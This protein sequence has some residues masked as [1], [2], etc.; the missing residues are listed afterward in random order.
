MT[1]DD[2]IA[3]PI[4]PQPEATVRAGHTWH[5]RIL[6]EGDLLDCL[7]HNRAHVGASRVWIGVVAMTLPKMAFSQ[8]VRMADTVLEQAEMIASVVN[9]DAPLGGSL[10][11]VVA[12]NASRKLR[13][14]ARRA[15]PHHAH[16]DPAGAEWLAKVQA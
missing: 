12:I 15:A 8:A 16:Q 10:R 9:G 7:A 6:H 2:Q 11:E 14:A 3:A 13:R 5:G 1:E 4:A